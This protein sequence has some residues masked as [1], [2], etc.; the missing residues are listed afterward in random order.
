MLN[1]ELASLKPQKPKI[2]ID[3]P[4]IVKKKMVAD[5]GVNN[6]SAK[7]AKKYNGPRTKCI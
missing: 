6:Y 4:K 1:S 2:G 5:G 3:K 7:M